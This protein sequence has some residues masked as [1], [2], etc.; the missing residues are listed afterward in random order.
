M[1]Q[2]NEKKGNF[3]DKAITVS[4]RSRSDARVCVLLCIPRQCCSHII[5]DIHW[6]QPG[7]RIR[8]MEPSQEQISHY[9][10]N[11]PAR[12]RLWDFPFS[13]N[14]WCELR[15]G[16][17]DEL[18]L[19]TETVHGKTN[20]CRWDQEDKIRLLTARRWRTVVSL[21][22]VRMHVPLVIPGCS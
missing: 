18:L 11:D 4:S 6:L 2:N 13:K 15:W 16:R 10:N 8:G 19:R 1:L 22:D 9:P 12:Q 17:G 21:H 5:R 14:W 7:R 20:S 3:I